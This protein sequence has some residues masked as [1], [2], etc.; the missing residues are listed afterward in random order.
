MSFASFIDQFDSTPP[1]K[2]QGYFSSMF[3]D[4]SDAE[5]AQAKEMMLTRGIQGDATDI[6]GLRFVAGTEIVPILLEHR[7][8]L[9]RH[10]FSTNASSI[11]L[12][13]ILT[14]DQSYLL[15][16]LHEISETD[17]TM[18]RELLANV[19]S[20]QTIPSDMNDQLIDLISNGENEDIIVQL[21]K[22]WLSIR[23]GA[24]DSIKK[25]QNFLPFIRSVVTEN[26]AR[27]SELLK[28][29]RHT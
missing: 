14:K 3:E 18:E 13:W 25:F 5:R 21:L 23:F 11:E 20:R 16:L 12:L 24:F 2:L 8:R 29:Y 4:M 17:Y 19:L 10:S 7:P 6:D 1:Q 26:P 15:T 22:S 9:A 27:R 28:H